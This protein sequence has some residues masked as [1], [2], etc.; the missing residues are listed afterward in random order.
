MKALIFTLLLVCS[1][2]FSQESGSEP[3]ENYPDYFAKE[4]KK[5]DEAGDSRFAQEFSNMLIYLG[6]I[7]AFI[8]LF[9]WI[10]KRMMQT[11]IEQSNQTKNIRVLETRP[12]NPKTTLYVVEIGNQSFALADSVNGVTYLNEVGVKSKNTNE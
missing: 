3:Q 8:Y 5:A 9:M 2:L 4:L 1:S 12:L 11:R 6:G 7:V 10:L